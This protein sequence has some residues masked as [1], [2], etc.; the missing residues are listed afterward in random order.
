LVSS[1]SPCGS[2]PL[3]EIDNIIGINAHALYQ[4]VLPIRRRP[5]DQDI[6]GGRDF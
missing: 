4:T 3:I 2:V 1:V 6:R 5:W